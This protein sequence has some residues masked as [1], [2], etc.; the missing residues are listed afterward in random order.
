MVRAG[1]IDYINCDPLFLGVEAMRGVSVERGVPSVLNTCLR[2]GAL[3]MSPVSSIEYARSAARYLLVPEIGIAADGPIRSVLL[4]SPVPLAELGGRVIGL[5]TESATTQVL[6]KI[7]LERRWR[8]P[9]RLEPWDLASGMPPG[10]VMVIGDP[11]LKATTSA[12]HPHAIDLCQEWVAMT[13]LPMTFALVCLR[14]EALAHH[15]VLIRRVAGAMRANAAAWPD[16]IERVAGVAAAAVGL[17]VPVVR[18]YLLGLQFRMTARHMEGLRLFFQLARDVGALDV[19]PGFEFL[20]EADATFTR[21][22]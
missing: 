15:E 19:V 10:P 8:I 6:L 11:A 17:P 21:E 13:G 9:A 5:S 14:R 7:L 20:S 3:D 2:D 12:S 16:G 4:L 18:A 22:A 1:R